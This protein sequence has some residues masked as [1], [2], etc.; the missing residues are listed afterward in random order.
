MIKKILKILLFILVY[1]VIFFIQSYFESELQLYILGFR[2]NLF[3]VFNLYIIYSYRNRLYCIESYFKNFGNLVH[4]LIVL[5]LPIVIITITLIYIYLVGNLK[6]K[7]PQFLIE[8]G[9]TSLIDIPIYYIWTFPF[10]A[11]IVICVIF[12]VENFSLI[13]LIFYSILFALS[14]LTLELESISK[15]FG[16]ENFSSLLLIMSF[17]FYNL[18]IIKS[19]KSIWVSVFSILISIYSFVL[20]FGS[21]NS[22]VIKTFFART[23]TEWDGL[24]LMKKINLEAVDVFFAGL[25]ILFAIFFFIFDRKS[26]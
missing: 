19:F 17:I 4:W 1:N 10:I 15:N 24:F 11:S 20:V 2:L 23:Y 5:I 21:K 14:F 18:S 6:Y 22:F 25:M 3:F 7:E 16:I 8:F 26:S 13:S 9:L 12:F